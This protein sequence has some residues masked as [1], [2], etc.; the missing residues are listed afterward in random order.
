MG[1]GSTWSG[2]VVGMSQRQVPSGWSDQL[3]LAMAVAVWGEMRAGSMLRGVAAAV[4]LASTHPSR[5]PNT[6]AVNAQVQ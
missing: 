3:S 1:V 6:T 5:L 2:S 4:Q